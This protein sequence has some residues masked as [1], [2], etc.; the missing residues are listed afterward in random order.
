MR[1]LCAESQSGA[2]G[3]RCQ[4][5]FAGGGGS[6]RGSRPSAHSRRVGGGKPNTR[7][8]SLPPSVMIFKRERRL[9]TSAPC[10]DFWEG[11]AASAAALSQFGGGDMGFHA[12]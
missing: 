3:L 2:A 5:D 1:R 10:L 6:G 11:E 4:L 7:R 8:A 9:P 12:R